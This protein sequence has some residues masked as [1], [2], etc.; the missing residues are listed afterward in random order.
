MV[1]HNVRQSLPVCDRAIVLDAGAV[2][3]RGTPDEIRVDPKVVKAYLG[4]GD[5]Q[6]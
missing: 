3:A 4:A 6:A 1:E 5:D 2:I